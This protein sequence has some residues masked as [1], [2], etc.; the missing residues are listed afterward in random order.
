MKKVPGPDWPRYR[1]GQVSRALGVEVSTLRYW[2]QVFPGIEPH[3]RHGQRLYR[4]SDLVLLTRI[5]RLLYEAGYTIRG[6]REALQ[7]SAD[8]AGQPEAAGQRAESPTA[9]ASEAARPE[10]GIL[11]AA[12]QELEDILQQLRRPAGQQTKKFGA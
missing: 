2:E 1:I 10:A 7:R 9:A 8:E 5:K 4:E 6:A 12:R 11:Q 3:R